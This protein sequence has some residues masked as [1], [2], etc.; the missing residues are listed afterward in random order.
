MLLAPMWRLFYAARK[1]S[2]IF[3]LRMS[4][5]VVKDLTNRGVRFHYNETIEKANK[6]AKEVIIVGDKHYRHLTTD[7][8]DATGRLLVLIG[9]TKASA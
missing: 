5:E 6:P 2:G 9:W 4:K 1:Y 7:Y 8:V 3:I